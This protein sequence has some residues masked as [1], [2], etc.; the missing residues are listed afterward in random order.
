[1]QYPPSSLSDVEGNY[2]QI[3]RPCTDHVQRSFWEGEFCVTSQPVRVALLLPM[4][5]AWAG[6]PQIAGAAALAVERV[7]ADKMLLPGRRLAYSW[8]NSGCSPKQALKAAAELLSGTVDKT[9][10]KELHAMIGPGCSSACEVTSY[11]SSGANLP[12]I[13]YSCTSPALSD[14]SNYEL[15][16]VA[17]ATLCPPWA[18]QDLVIGHIAW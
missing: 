3:F 12:Q 15:V 9:I 6:G 18:C 11:L 10:H 1:M 13:S 5:G 7:N 17:L 8:A 14:K 4:D 16:R 2:T